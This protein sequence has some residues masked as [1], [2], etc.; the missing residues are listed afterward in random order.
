[1]STSSQT[2]EVEAKTPPTYVKALPLREYSDIEKIKSDLD[3]G[4]ILIVKLTPLASKNI[5]EVKRVID[6]LKVY[7]ETIGGDIA[8]LGEER[9]VITPPP[10]KIWRKGKKTD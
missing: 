5:E 2:A 4:N 10:V 3:S 7:A 6:E 9:I 1:M 8:R